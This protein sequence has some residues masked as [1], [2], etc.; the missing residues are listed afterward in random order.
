MNLKSFCQISCDEIDSTG[1]TEAQKT[2]V[3]SAWSLF[4]SNILDTSRNIF[5]EF[6][7]ENPEFLKLFDGLEN[8]AMHKHTE[9]AL[10]SYTNLIDHGLRS[11]TEFSSELF[12]ISKLHQNVTGVDAAKLNRIIK[13]SVL[14]QVNRH[15]SKTLEDG[16]DAFFFKIESTF[17]D[18][19]SL[20]L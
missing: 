4:K 13:R 1:L 11:P 17:D 14:D 7:E 19:M 20:E 18:S 6:Y 5:A 3:I 2:A 12:R 10:R 8:A 15:R 9:E 16:L